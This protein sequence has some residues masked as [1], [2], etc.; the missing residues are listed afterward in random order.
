MNCVEIYFAFYRPAPL[1]EIFNGKQDWRCIF[2]HVSAHWCTPDATWAFFDP[3]GSGTRIHITHLHDEVLDRLATIR[4]VAQ[5]ILV[6]KPD[7]RKFRLPIHPPM[8]CV[9]Q[10]S[11]LIG[12][13]AYSPWGFRKMLHREGAEVIWSRDE[14]TAITEKGERTSF[15]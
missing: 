10:C 15:L 11:S 4:A 7:G 8:N 2:G 14:K 6:F 1:K 13:R 3:Q 12:R 5:E 9:T